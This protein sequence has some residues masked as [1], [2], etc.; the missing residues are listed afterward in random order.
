MDADWNCQ[1]I[2]S[3]KTKNMKNYVEK[4]DLLTGE[5]FKPKRKN[6]KFANAR[7]Q[8]RFNNRKQ[9]KVAIKSATILP[10]RDIPI[11]RPTYS[12]PSTHDE[13]VVYVGIGLITGGLLIYFLMK[14]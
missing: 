6:Q 4:N 5:R 12:F 8:V 10:Q 14:K 11:F 9:K 13:I 1:K 3:S 2:E 7:N